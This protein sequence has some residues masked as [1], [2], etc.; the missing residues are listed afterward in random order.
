MFNENLLYSETMQM[1]LD[2]KN[3]QFMY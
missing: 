2:E 3:S 1:M